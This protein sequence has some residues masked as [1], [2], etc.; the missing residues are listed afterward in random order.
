M[1]HFLEDGGWDEEKQEKCTAVPSISSYRQIFTC[2]Y[3][4]VR[5]TSSVNRFEAENA[6]CLGLSGEISRIYL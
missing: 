2:I 6:N 5:F 3:D 1:K 4:G